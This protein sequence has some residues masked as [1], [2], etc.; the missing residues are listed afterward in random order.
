MI[1]KT[2]S[3]VNFPLMIEV[4]FYGI[5][6]KKKKEISSIQFIDDL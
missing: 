3:K 1:S 4:M 5:K 6:I 2:K